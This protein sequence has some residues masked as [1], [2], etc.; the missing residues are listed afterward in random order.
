MQR[1]DEE[2]SKAK[3]PF[4]SCSQERTYTVLRRIIDT[5]FNPASQV[6]LESD[7]AQ[8]YTNLTAP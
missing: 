7:V 4:L 3:R 2:T 6:Q 8:A 1:S 5:K